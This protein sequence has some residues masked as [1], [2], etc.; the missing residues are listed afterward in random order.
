LAITK[1][2]EITRRKVLV[3]AS[4][5]GA[6][7]V[8][9]SVFGATAAVSA[10]AIPDYTPEDKFFG[11][12]YV[13]V[14]EWRDLPERYR[15]I[16]GG[17]KGTDTRFSFYMV[18]P[19]RYQGR[20]LHA[21]EGG[22]GGNEHTVPNITPDN[23]TA[24]PTTNLHLAF[25]QGAYLVESNQGH[26]GMDLSGA[27][28]D[29]S[30][31]VWRASAESARFSKAVAQQMYGKAPHHGYIFGGSGGGIRSLKCLEEVNG[32]WDGGVP[33][34]IPHQ[35][36]GNFFSLELNVQ[37]LLGKE[38]M[39]RLFD[40]I[41]V[42]GVGDIYTGLS[43]REAEELSA[44]YSA[45][46]PRGIA[47]DQGTGTIATMVWTWLL[48][49]IEQNDPTYFDDFWNKPGYEGHDNPDQFRDDLVYVKTKVRRVLSAREFAD[50]QPTQKVFDRFGFGA[51]RFRGVAGSRL[52]NPDRPMAL[53]LEDGRQ[54]GN[55]GCSPIKFTSGAGVG[56][57]LAV[58]GVVGD[59]VTV[60][61]IGAKALED[62]KEGDEVVVD[63][64][65]YLA[66]CYFYRHQVEPQFP[67]WSFA[68]ANGRPKYVQRPRVDVPWADTYRYKLPGKKVIVVHGMADRGTWPSSGVSYRDNLRKNVGDAIDSQFRLWL[69]EHQDHGGGAGLESTYI[70]D[71][72]GFVQEAMRQVIMWV[73]QGKAPQTS[74]QFQYTS[75][76]DVILAPSAP[77]R[78]AIQSVV[79]VT[80]NGKAGRVDVKVGTPV[81]FEITAEAPPGAGSIV[82]VEWDF[83]GKATWP[84]T[85]SE[86]DGK[87]SKVRLKTRHTFTQPG[88][89]FTA[90][91]VTG[92]LDGN[93]KT[94]LYHVPNLGR[95]R[96]IVV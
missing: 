78:K 77:A 58:I 66:Y 50:Y 76:H 89:Y 70:V 25:A 10:T 56:R 41:D 8:V 83:D 75:D 65:P 88:T 35:S 53:V 43:P 34:I 30:I 92:Q 46:F 36:Q 73:E 24:F 90:C 82:K 31:I 62:I 93:A 19:E 42:G 81:E 16:H 15:Y 67:E 86:L 38:K 28:N 4:A 48:S 17:F 32:V 44:L 51:D 95:I 23:I 26:L 74:S 71:L 84:V 11:S 18:A 27:K 57:S 13:D 85:H 64:R 7:S 60:N 20:F 37:R 14:D 1:Q 39:A 47:L 33:F 91:R 45:G 80:A 79:A 52:A 21:L 49:V 63:N 2:H 9:H 61:G 3:A 72:G 59:A 22:P 55:M 40:S 87:A 29:H 94:A 54:M 5:L 68:M 69:Q 12:A 6:V 96:V